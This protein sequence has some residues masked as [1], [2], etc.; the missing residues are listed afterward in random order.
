MDS[1]VQHGNAND[2]IEAEFDALEAE[3]PNIQSPCR[4]RVRPRRHMGRAS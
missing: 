3:M 4:Q 2:A 1:F